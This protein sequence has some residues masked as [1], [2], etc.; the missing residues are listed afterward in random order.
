MYVC[1]MYVCLIYLF[2]YVC[3]YFFIDLCMYLHTHTFLPIVKVNISH[4]VE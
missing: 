4:C 3:T 2:M 1:I